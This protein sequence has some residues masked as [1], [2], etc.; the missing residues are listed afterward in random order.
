MESKDRNRTKKSIDELQE[1]GEHFTRHLIKEK[2]RTATLQVK[3]DE[4]NEKIANLRDSNKQKAMS[5]LNKYITTPN[6]AYHRVDGVNPAMLAEENQKKIVKK[7]ES[8]LGKTLIRRNEVENENEAVKGKIDKLRRKIYNDIKKREG[9]EKELVEVKGD[10]DEIMKRAAAVAAE[11][12]RLIERRS[13]V[14]QQDNEKQ[15]IFEKEY[16][17]LC[18][19]I[20]KQAK[21]LEESI[22]KAADSVT[23]QLSIVD[24][25]QGWSSK[26]VS[27]SVDD[28]KHLE[29]RVAALDIEYE[30]TQR[31]LRENQWKIHHFEEKFKELREVSGLSSTDDIIRTFV[32]NEEECFSIFNYTQAVNHDCDKITEQVTKLREE[33]NKYR[34]EQMEDESARSVTMNIYKE[35]LEEVALEREKLCEIT[36]EGRRTIESIAHRVTAL[37]FKLE[38]HKLKGNELTSK[39]SLPTQLQTDRTLTTIG[40]GE[41]SERNILNLM[42]LIETRSIEI[43]EAFQNQMAKS[44]RSRRP[45]L[46]LT[47]VMFAQAIANIQRENLTDEE[48]DKLEANEESSDDDDDGFGHPMSVND[49][50]REAAVS[51]RPSTT[52]DQR[53]TLVVQ[54]SEQGV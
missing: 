49:I 44:K 17:E 54:S 48:S 37:F 9:M 19:F 25:G 5:L 23:T 14:L 34:R 45:N 16:N 52:A 29:D 12:E 24:G 6:D 33:L 15:T 50:R 11:R 4:V 13:Q 27:D 8:R 46:K 22:A 35:S 1:R 40:G 36:I 28:I 10:V 41:L 53:A 26:S 30:A 32:K 43:V 42:E 7:L 31:S 39:N 21:S 20:A 18:L 2:Q 38:C 3:L 47:P 51:M